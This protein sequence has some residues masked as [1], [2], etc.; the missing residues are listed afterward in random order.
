MLGLLLAAQARASDAAPPDVKVLTLAS[1]DRLYSVEHISVLPPAS[2]TVRIDYTAPGVTM[3][4]H[5]RFRYRLDGVDCD[6]VDAGERRSAYYT[7]LGAGTYRF[8]VTAVTDGGV[9]STVP[10]TLS[11]VI[12]LAFTQTPWFYGMVACLVMAAL[13]LLHRLRLRRQENR[14]VEYAK[15]RQAERESIARLLHDTFLQSVQGLTYAF[16]GIANGL[17]ARSETR[18]QLEHILT[19]AEGIIVEGRDQVAGLRNLSTRD[20]ER[21]LRNVA[22]TLSQAFPA[23]FTFE[24]HGA[25]RPLNAIVADEICMFAR[26]ALFNAFRHGQATTISVTLVHGETAL[27]LTVQDDG[28][29]IEEPAFEGASRTGHWGLRGMRERAAAIAGSLD[30]ASASGRGTTL[31]LRVPAGAAYMC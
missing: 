10:A 30:I 14:I 29:G 2:S 22:S 8:S 23:R 27:S 17:P 5:V 15:A 31:T 7:N 16:Q 19:L 11:F 20:I 4:A 25:A 9:W 3:P 18:L 26:E 13:C 21:E 24:E 6:W 28:R 1:A 12:P